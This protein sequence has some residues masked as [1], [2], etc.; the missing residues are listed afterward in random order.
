MKTRLDADQPVQ[1]R[2]GQLRGVLAR[3]APVARVTCY[4]SDCQAYARAIGQADTVLDAQGGTE[5]VSTLQQHLRFTQG[6]EQ[7][8]CL[9]LRPGGLL[10]WY[11]RCCSTG[12][13]NITKD[14]RLSYVGLLHTAFADRRSDLDAG[15]GPAAGLAVYTGRARAPVPSRRLATLGHMARI[16]ASVA[17]ARIDGGW[18]TSPFFRREDGR[19]LRDARVLSEQELADARRGP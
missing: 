3:G 1:C 5:V 19:P 7:L 13:A 6:S 16:I 11:A 10:R 4:C 15:F 8:A 12:I 17:A 18:K 9:R 2:C 14:Q